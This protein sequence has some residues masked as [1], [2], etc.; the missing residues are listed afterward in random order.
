MITAGLDIGLRY[1]KAVILK[2]WERVGFAI[3]PA[4]FDHDRSAKTVL[5]KAL[6]MAGLKKTDIDYI[7]ATGYGRRKVSRWP[8][9]VRQGN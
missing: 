1:V 5:Q 3:A 7:V 2:D 8:E 9:S 4:G 6:K